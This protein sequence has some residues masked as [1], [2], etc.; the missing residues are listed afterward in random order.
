MPDLDP[1]IPLKATPP[2]FD[3]L[4]TV[5]KLQGVQQGVLQNRL[6][7][8]Q[9]DSKIALGRAVTAATDPTTGKTDWAKALGGLSQDPQGSFAVPELAGQVL[10]R[11]LKELQVSGA[12]LTLSND[13]WKRVSSVAGGLLARKN[14]D[15]TPADLTPEDVRTEFVDRLVTSGQFNDDKSIGQLASTLQKLPKT[16]AE[17]R[18]YL[19]NLALQADFTSERIGALLGNVTPV[20]TGAGTLMTQTSPLTGQTKAG[21]IIDKQLSPSEANTPAYTYKDPVTGQEH[22]VTKSQAAAAAP[23]ATPVGIVSGLPVGAEGARTLAATKAAEQAAALGVAA[24]QVPARKALLGN[25]EGLV[26]QFGS[27]PSADWKKVAA[28]LVNANNPWGPLFDT[29]KIASQ[30]EFN[31]QAAM[32]AQEQF[33]A[34]GGTGTDAKLDSAMST[35]PNSALSRMGNIGI[36]RMLKGNED[37]LSAKNG[38]WQAWLA[39]GKG[40]ESYGQ[41]T[42]QFNQIYDPRVFQSVYMGPEE[43]AAMLKGMTEAEVKKF[44]GAYA[45][46]VKFGWIPGGQ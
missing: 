33:K 30:E 32:L 9:V 23:G 11:Q 39:S 36:I 20:D 41:F 13:R 22:I 43:R 38:A 44:R 45:N 5:G 18:S 12:D 31:K 6:L 29:K 42:T 40:P 1:T 17:I 14:A 35:S 16:P 19:T 26:G 2:T 28:G 37:A 34:L 8:Q 15:G 10:D 3:P 7:G 24:E 27:G 46:A 25:L 21:A 4:A